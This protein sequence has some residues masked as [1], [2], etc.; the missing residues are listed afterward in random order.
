MDLELE[1]TS[2][3]KELNQNEVDMCDVEFGRDED[4][5]EVLIGNGKVEIDSK[6]K[7]KICSDEKWQYQDKDASTSDPG[8]TSTSGPINSNNLNSF[9]YEQ[10]CNDN[11]DDFDVYGDDISDYDDN[12]DFLYEDEDDYITMLSQFDNVDLP[13]GVEAALP[14]LKDLAPSERIKPSATTLSS[15]PDLSES[16]R[17]STILDSTES[18][19]KTTI[20]DLDENKSKLA[21][22]SS[23]TDPEEVSSNEKEE[24]GHM[25]KLH[26]KQ[27][28]TVV[29]FSD[30]H[31]SR[32]GFLGDQQPPKNWA[33]KIQDEWKILEKNLP[34]TIFVR[35]YES[36]MELLRALMVGPSG[37]PYHDGLFVF[38]CLFPPSYPN[39][40]PMVYYYSG[41]LRLNPNLY[42]CG[43]VCLSLLGTWTGKS[44]EMW[45]KENSTMLQVLV[46]IQ[47]LILNA[48][49]FFNEPGYE[50]SY[51]GVEGERKSRAYNEETF[52]LSLKTMLYT[53]RRPPQH[54][55][56]LVTHHFRNH[57]HDI[58]VACKAYM[59]GA[60]VG[61]VVVKD[62]VIEGGKIE[63]G[64]SSHFKTKVGQMMNILI[65]NFTK[66]GCTNCEQFRTSVNRP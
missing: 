40:P 11:D 42:E 58:L 1:Q 55:E 66:I 61:T 20:S 18:K 22:S 62:G 12:D 50:K 60:I 48:Q 23:S 15:V 32:M 16:K 59:E 65:T 24:S 53:L 47:A 14:W 63:K 33:K 39:E 26:F 28:D 4:L 43:K 30:H 7:T 27:F 25:P 64:S 34:D 9:N 29:D 54:F 17:N 56:D 36:R 44:T 38:D 19:M 2:I 45:S 8:K 57:A 46:S 52:I 37:T 35:V 21:S 3:S 6:G 49:P 31:Y 41:G 51:V 10:S 13:P 5:L